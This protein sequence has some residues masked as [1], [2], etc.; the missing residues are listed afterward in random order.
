RAKLRPI[1]EKIRKSEESAKETQ[2]SLNRLEKTSN[3]LATLAIECSDKLSDKSQAQ[4]YVDYFLSHI[5][6]VPDSFI[7]KFCKEKDVM[8]AY[9]KKDPV[10]ELAKLRKKFVE[11]ELKHIMKGDMSS[12][13]MQTLLNEEVDKINKQH[14]EVSDKLI[15]LMEEDTRLGKERS[16]IRSYYRI[17]NWSDITQGEPIPVIKETVDWKPIDGDMRTVNQLKQTYILPYGDPNDRMTSG[18]FDGWLEDKLSVVP[19]GPNISDVPYMDQ[20]SAIK[21][22]SDNGT[23]PEFIINAK[24][25]EEISQFEFNKEYGLNVNITTLNDIW[26]KSG[27][28]KDGVILTFFQDEWQGSSDYTWI[29]DGAKWVNIS[30]SNPK[31]MTFEECQSQM[32][33]SPNL[34]VFNSH[35]PEEAY[36]VFSNVQIFPVKRSW[37]K[38]LESDD[39]DEMIYFKTKPYLSEFAVPAKNYAGYEVHKNFGGPGDD[40]IMVVY[41]KEIFG[42]GIEKT[43]DLYCYH[44]GGPEGYLLNGNEYDMCNAWLK[45]ATGVYNNDIK[46]WEVKRLPR[47]Y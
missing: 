18:K 45:V 19:S 16:N 8:K 24:D 36:E 30:P 43:C 31:Y 4:P 33:K 20:Y 12:G 9:D 26:D 11:N 22:I 32:N 15:S 1:E 46:K 2:A 25:L 39:A 13:F 41:E 10:Q 47:E 29:F 35:D 37:L 34:R 27:Q 3:H 38:H 21:V 14:R 23:V 7:F 17:Y 28:Y 42:K 44:W 40:A 6:S 5:D